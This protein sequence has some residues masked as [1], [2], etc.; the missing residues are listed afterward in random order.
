MRFNAKTHFDKKRLIGKKRD[1]NVAQNSRKNTNCKVDY[2]Y[3]KRGVLRL[4]VRR[5][6]M[7]L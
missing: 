7:F 3:S 4:L 6:Q 2:L 1:E 5:G